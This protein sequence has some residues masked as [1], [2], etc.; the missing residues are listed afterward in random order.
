MRR[1]L[2]GRLVDL[3]VKT[4]RRLARGTLLDFDHRHGIETQRAAAQPGCGEGRGFYEATTVRHFR[5]VVAQ[6]PGPLEGCS[7]LDIGSGKGRVV[8]LAMAWPFRR[9]E[10]V[11]Y[12]PGLHATAAD[13]LRRY[14]GRR[15]ARAVAL[16]CGDALEAPLPDGDLVVFFYNS[17]HGVMLEAL[18]DRL[19]DRARASRHRLLFIYSNATERYRV[20][21]RAAFRLVHEGASPLDLIWWGNRRFVVYA[22][23]DGD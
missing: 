18:L 16:R 21:R 14:R 4:T 17:M 15:G 23:G 1:D 20:D 12:L 6:V 10:G 11:E 9:V 22:V 19:E 3:L 8:L 7:F 5:A 2:R 13:N